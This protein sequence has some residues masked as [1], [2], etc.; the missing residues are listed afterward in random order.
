MSLSD[1]IADMLTTIRNGQG[2]RLA[3]VSCPHSKLRE[4]V[5]EVLKNEGYIKKYS[6]VNVRTGID[7][8]N[9]KLAYFEGSPVIKEIKRV[10]KPGLRNYSSIKNLPKVSNGIGISIVST[11]KGVMADHDARAA[12]VGGE[13]LC[14][15]F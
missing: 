13:I 12:N 10:S 14:N 4:G 9:I 3:S 2:V 11:S 6:K 8:I 7:R 5:L 1:P 15:I